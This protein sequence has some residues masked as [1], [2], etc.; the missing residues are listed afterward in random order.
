M[1]KPGPVLNLI[2]IEVLI[3]SYHSISSDVIEYSPRMPWIPSIL[4]IY[5]RVGITCHCWRGDGI[6]IFYPEPWL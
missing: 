3:V 4:Q 2:K 5:V 6:R 1:V